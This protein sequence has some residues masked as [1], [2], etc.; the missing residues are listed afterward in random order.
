MS[1][2]TQDRQVGGGPPDDRPPDERVLRVGLL[3]RLL[4]RP[5]VGALVGALAVFAFFRIFDEKFTQIIGVSRF[6]DPA[7]TLGIMAVAVA[8]LMIGGEFDL[9]AGV[10]TGSTGLLMGMLATELEWNIWLAML[11]ALVFA[12]VIG[13]VNG[14]LVVKTKLPSFIITL[15][16]FFL[17]RG[18]N[19]GVTRLVTDEVRVTGVNGAAGYDL[20]FNLLGRQVPILGGNF[21]IAIFWWIALVVLGTWVLRRTRI[22]NW[23][24]SVGGDA[25]A[26][27][28]VG[29][30]VQRVKISLFMLTSSAAWLVGMMRAVELRGT[31]ASEGIGQEFIFII[32]AVIGGCLLTGGYGSVIGAALGALIFGMTQTGIGF[33]GWDTEWFFSF[34]GAML[35]FAVFVNDAV[36]KRAQEVRR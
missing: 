32:A 5:E 24:Y 16:T 29:V 35:L 34:L 21:Q 1:T 2:L 22:G 12:L 10:M 23:I 19:T 18:A 4:L 33:A 13:F 27:R 36:R 17:L 14:L 9:S 6:L 20:A 26:A 3:R 25:E 11:A 30:P 31:V 28:S 7:A 8:L 15:G